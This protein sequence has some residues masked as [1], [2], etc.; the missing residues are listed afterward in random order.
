MLVFDKEGE[1][2]T[3]NRHITTLY[4]VQNEGELATEINWIQTRKIHVAPTTARSTV[5]SKRNPSLGPGMLLESN[6]PGGILD[7]PRRLVKGKKQGQKPMA[8]NAPP[9]K[10]GYHTP[11]ERLRLSDRN[12]GRPEWQKF[13]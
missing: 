10:G 3:Q 9:P 1:L 4:S 2:A 12:R 5:S 13:S 11:A 6:I 7:V 8:R